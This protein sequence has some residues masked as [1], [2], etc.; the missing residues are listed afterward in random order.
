MNTVL[1]LAGL[2]IVGLVIATLFSRKDDKKIEALEVKKAE[3][4]KQ[5]D[6][7]Q[8]EQAG[9]KD[10]ATASQAHATEEQKKDF[11]KEELK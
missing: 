2:G 9:L 1:I 5:L 6:A 7:L 8:K 11:W 10:A 4:Q 3:D